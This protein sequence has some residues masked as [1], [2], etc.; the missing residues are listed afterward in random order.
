MTSTLDPNI[1]NGD[2]LEVVV[3]VSGSGTL[4]QAILDHQDDRYRVSRVIADVPC[5]ALERAE[6]VGVETRVVELGADRAAWNVT[7]ADVIAETNPDLVVSAGFMKILGAGVLDRFGGS[8]INTHPALLPSFPGAHAVR[9][10][11][12]HGVKV[13]GSTVHFIDAGVDTGPIIAQAAVEV[14]PG[15]TESSLHERIKKIERQLIVS[16]LRSATI[17][18][19]TRKVEFIHE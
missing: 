15:D 17:D 13:T 10:A 1:P 7:L 6:Q 18:E 16:V 3:L 19:T 14:E 2:P 8:I 9:D 11:L 5:P 12:A 4:L